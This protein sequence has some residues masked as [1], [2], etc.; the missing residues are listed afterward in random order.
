MPRVPASRAPSVSYRLAVLSRILAAA[1]GGYL[2]AAACAAGLALALAHAMPRAE[3]VLSATMLAWLAYALA[4]AW[5]FHA[6][7]AWR[8]W[9][10]VLLPALLLGALPLWNAFGGRA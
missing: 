1:L 9:A 2:L 6:R 5:A 10:G 7:N 3:A 8:A 4:A